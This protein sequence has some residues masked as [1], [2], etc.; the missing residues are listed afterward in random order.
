MHILTYDLINANFEDYEKLKNGIKSN[1]PLASKLTESCWFIPTAPD[2]LS[3]ITT[4]K[5]YVKKTDRL[6]VSELKGFPLGCNILEDPNPLKRLV[7][8]PFGS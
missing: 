7:R 5:Q 8:K 2:T 1:Y 6:V 4:I 3:I